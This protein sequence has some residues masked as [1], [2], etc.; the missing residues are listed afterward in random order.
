MNGLESR[1]ADRQAQQ[2]HSGNSCSC[3]GTDRIGLPFRNADRGI[4]VLGQ[5]L[6]SMSPAQACTWR[7]RCIVADATRRVTN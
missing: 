3:A 2:H 4:L 7:G 1:K 5:T 6:I